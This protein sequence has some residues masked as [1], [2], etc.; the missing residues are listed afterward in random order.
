MDNKIAHAIL[1]SLLCG[2]CGGATPA[3]PEHR[4]AMEQGSAAGA[5]AG[6]ELPA[7][8]RRAFEQELEPQHVH[9]IESKDGKLRARLEAS[10]QPTV[11]RSDEAY[12]LVAPLAGAPLRC[13]AWDGR[14]DPANT[15][16]SLVSMTL[17]A[18][19]SSGTLNGYQFE[20]LA[21]GLA[22]SIPYLYARALYT[23]AQDKGG[24]KLGQI[25]YLVAGGD[26]FSVGCVHDHPGLR[27]T[28]VRIAKGLVTSMESSLRGEEA[29]LR[30]REV[31]LIDSTGPF[32][33]FAVASLNKKDD[34]GSMEWGFE[35][36]LMLGASQT[37]VAVDIVSWKRSNRNG[38]IVEA[39][40]LKNLNGNTDYDL[41]LEASKAGYGVKGS[42][43]SKAYQTSLE[44]DDP[45]LDVVRVQALI[46]KKVL[47]EGQQLSVAQYVPNANPSATVTMSMRRLER[48]QGQW[49]THMQIADIAQKARLDA[50]GML[51]R[52]QLPLGPITL[53]V[54]RG[55]L[56][57][58]L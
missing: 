19:K 3:P 14:M 55:W 4:E 32:N 31:F 54:K 38:E 50:Q 47:K 7:H 13:F 36:T 44:L 33:G 57:G 51:E 8:V 30:Y 39:R 18:S 11:T 34:G 6:S 48:P 5:R 15:I 23:Q 29:G 58:T 52:A 20:A 25:Q 16:R 12:M 24:D 17:E 46:R 41:T 9:P 37:L 26:V 53:E 21:S 40:F 35:S 22:G 27:T 43:K 2:A 45:L 42:L 28:F 1:L 56:H 10:S 49:N